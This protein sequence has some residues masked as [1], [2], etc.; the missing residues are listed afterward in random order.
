MTRE[1]QLI[2]AVNA[3]KRSVEDVRDALR[4][5]NEPQ[6]QDDFAAVLNQCDAVRRAH[7]A[8]PQPTIADDYAN[9]AGLLRQIRFSEDDQDR[10]RFRALRGARGSLLED[11]R[12]ILEC[13]AA[14]GVRPKEPE[15]ALPD[16]AMLETAG[17]EGQL[18]ALQS[19]IT[20]VETM[21]T[22]RLLPEAAAD[23]PREQVAIVNHYV[24]DMRRYTTSIRLSI[25]IGDGIDLAVIERAAS[26]MGRA[27]VAMIDTV[28]ARASKATESLRDAV[29][30]IGKPVKK[31]IGGVRVLVQLVRRSDSR[32]GKPA[33]PPP[34]PD[35]YL[36]QAGMMILRGEAPP[37]H[38]APQITEL[39][40]SRT[41]LADLNPL[42][43]LTALKSLGL[44]GTKVSDLTPLTQLT[45]LE[46][47]DLMETQ[48]S[49]LAPLAQLTALESLD[50][51]NTQVSD[52][53]P[54][55]Q[56]TALESLD[57][58]NT[59]VSDLTP[60]AQLAALKSLILFNTS[61]SD[62]TPLAHLTALKTLNLFNAHVTDL[63]PLAQLNALESLDLTG[64][65][66]NDL[67]PLAHLTALESLDLHSTQVSDITP[68]AQ[69]TTLQSLKLRHTQVS[70]ISPL[71]HLTAL[72]SLDLSYTKVSDIAALSAIS[73]LTVI[74]ESG[75]RAMALRATLTAGSRVRV[76]KF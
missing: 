15:T 21:L 11:M 40:F 47:L 24:Q 64:T 36:G 70:D 42:A 49:D 48:V 19:R 63:N 16:T 76:K 8:V 6:W 59:Q 61:V 45:A 58:S 22:E 13:A 17:R 71:A 60:L 50:L 57:L 53:T 7:G 23:K 28:R 69:L 2:T 56:L 10:E 54:L 37:A 66:V 33:Q 5:I 18:I 35:G 39:Y 52:L 68:L 20:S 25:S 1:E 55:T 41:E 14:M 65:K 9:L 62:L 30:A 43:H 72:K 32:L 29:T 31:L 75:R 26:S 27:T 3:T 51:S 67:S 74:V 38:W 44:W 34:L 46:S 73:G 4:Q 12:A